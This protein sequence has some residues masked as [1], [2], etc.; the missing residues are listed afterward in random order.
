VRALIALLTSVLLGASLLV[1]IALVAPAASSPAEAAT[2]SGSAFDPGNIISDAN[3][4]AGDAMS[5]ADV[6]SF[7]NAQVASCGNANCLRSGSFSLD[8]EAADAMCTAITGGS[9]LSAAT[10]ITR[11]ALACGISPRVILTTLQKEQSLVTTAS[12]SATSILYA[13]GYACPDTGSGC[14]PAYSG[15][16]NQIYRAAWQWKRYGNPVGT[17]NYFTWLAPGAAHAIQYSPTV[18]CGTRSVTVQNAAT[19]A[20]Y[21][22]TPYTPNQAALANLYGTGDS[23]SSYGN[24]NFWR[25]YSDWFGSPTGVVQPFGSADQITGGSETVHVAGWAIDPANSAPTTVVVTID[26]ASAATLTAGNTRADVGAAYPASGAAHGFDATID[27]P[28][29]THTVCVTAKTVA[30]TASAQLGCASVA[31][32]QASP[33]GAVD[34]A[35][36]EPGGIT[37]AGWTI[38]PDV[39]TAPVA[40][41][42]SIDGQVTNLTANTARPDI[43][44]V[45][46]AAGAAHG[47]STTIPASAGAHTVCITAVNVGAGKDTALASCSTTLVPGSTPIGSL[48]SVTASGSNIVV[49]GWTL[50]GDTTSFIHADVYI[51]G[52]GTRTNANAGRGDIGASYPAY[53]S[54]HGINRTFPVS[55]GVH[56]VCVYAINTGPGATVLLGCRSVKVGNDPIGSLD[57]VTAGSGQVTVSGWAW[58]PD[59]AA[60]IA[61]H[62][63]VGAQGTATTA[64]G[65]RPD[66]ARAYPAAGAAHGFTVTVA[67]PRGNQ[68]VCAYGID[69]NGG[70]NT[71]LGCRVVAVG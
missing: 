1:G 57:S 49:A 35:R 61:V 3:F 54:A 37:V 46:P 31:I 45:Y 5:A 70:S 38:D 60:P 42:V 6:Q 17:S 26:G 20:L 11:V 18:S 4:Y 40:L 59:T 32:A 62:V 24:R 2:L 34:T 27:A 50:D 7:L 22:Y 14:D 12:P 71:L 55:N 30:G 52:Q 66:I 19:A 33:F 51:D 16:G 65:A 67:A 58:D 47:F 28:A 69:S 43:A 53:G 10:V 36:A 48:D 8:S 29:G 41:R 21:Y 15:L 63:Y 25:I 9:G 68:Q 23:C 39:P 13:M 64:A 56:N 44:Q